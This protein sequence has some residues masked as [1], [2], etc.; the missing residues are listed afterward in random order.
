[1][2]PSNAGGFRRLAVTKPAN[3]NGKVNIKQVKPALRLQA[4]RYAQAIR[5]KLTFNILTMKN[6]LIIIFVFLIHISLQIYSQD[7]FNNFKY[8]SN[9]D[10]GQY[11]NIDGIQIYYEI[12]GQG[13]PLLLLHGGLGSIANFEK[14]IPE[15]AKHYLIIAPDSPGHGRS[16]Q[17]D[18]LSYPFLSDYISKFIDY[19]KLDSLYI[20][21]WSDGG[22]IGLIL[23]AERSDKVKKLIAV[24][25]NTRLKDFGDEGIEWMNNSMIDW[26]KNNKDWLN[27]YL[28]L[29]PQ[30]EKIDTYLKNT[31]KM[32]LTDIYIPQNKIE[33]IKI[34]TM[35]LQGDKDGIKLEHTVELYRTINHSQLCILPNTSHFVFYEKPDLM[36]KIAIGFFSSKK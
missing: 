15:L 27:N 4:G 33:S 14:C 30:P 22:I 16:S 13:I 11:I 23:A 1:L 20:M 34:P 10:K 9:P 18:S 36:N 2:Q 32:Y 24:G 31:Q 35:I 8:G 3:D 25:A 12:Y 29:T 7:S 5:K 17:T 6:Q 19:L 28:S 21:G 26:A